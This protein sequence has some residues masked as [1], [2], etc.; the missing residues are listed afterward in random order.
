MKLQPTIGRLSS[1]R[2]L[3]KTLLVALFVV[4]GSF[5]FGQFAAPADSGCEWDLEALVT[6]GALKGDDE[7]EIRFN[8][9]WD[10][11][12]DA[13][14]GREATLTSIS[15]PAPTCGATADGYTQGTTGWVYRLLKVADDGT[16]T[17]YDGTTGLLAGH[18]TIGSFT[19]GTG[20][21]GASS[22]G[23]SS[24]TRWAEDPVTWKLEANWD[25]DF[26]NED[27]VPIS[28]TFLVTNDATPHAAPTNV[29]AVREAQTHMYV[30]WTVTRVD[31]ADPDVATSTTSDNV[32][33]EVDGACADNFLVV[34]T[35]ARD[36]AEMGD[37]CRTSHVRRTAT[38][39][40]TDWTTGA[41]N[42][43]K[44]DDTTTDDPDTPLTEADLELVGRLG[45]S[46]SGLCYG[47]DYNVTV[48][49]R[50]VSMTGTITNHGQASAEVSV[51]TTGLR[52]EQ[53]TTGTEAPAVG[54]AADTRFKI[55]EGETLQIN[56]NTLVNLAVGGYVCPVTADD[57]ATT[58]FDESDCANWTREQS[59]NDFRFTA[60]ASSS[61]R[62]GVE[63]RS[64][65]DSTQSDD[66]IVLTG[67]SAGATR[68]TVNAR[69]IAG[70]TSVSG[71]I[72]VAVIGNN[73]PMFAVESAKITWNVGVEGE[74]E[75]AEAKALA[76]DVMNDFVNS[77]IDEDTTDCEVNDDSDDENCDEALYFTVSKR[78]DGPFNLFEI[79]KDED[80]GNDKTNSVITVNQGPFGFGASAKTLDEVLNEFE[81]DGAD[82]PAEI[83]LT[84][85]AY[86][87]IAWD[88][89]GS[90]PRCVEDAAETESETDV[91][92][93]DTMV[94]Y[95]DIIETENDK[96]YVRSISRSPFF[97]YGDGN[98]YLRPLTE[99][100]GGGSRTQRV[101]SRFADRDSDDLCFHIDSAQN[102]LQT[103]DNRTIAKVTNGG[104]STCPNGEITL[105]MIL[106]STNPDD[107]EG[108]ALLGLQG[109]H[110]VSVNVFACELEVGGSVSA[111]ERADKCSSGTVKV[112][113]WVVYGANVGP[114][115][116][117]TAE[118]A[119]GSTVISDIYEVT[120]GSGLTL[121][122][123]ATDP[124]PS[125][126]KL[127]W[128]N[129]S[130]CSPCTG[131]EENYTYGFHANARK[132]PSS[133]SQSGNEYKYRIRIPAT[134]G[135]FGSVRDTI[136]YESL[137]ADKVYPVRVCA[138]DLHNERA[139]MTF[140]VKVKDRAESPEVSALAARRDLSDVFMLVGD[141]DQERSA[142]R[143]FTDSDGD[144]LEYEAYCVDDTGTKEISCSPLRV[145]IDDDGLI[146][147]TP[148]TSDFPDPA[149]GDPVTQREWTVEVAATSDNEDDPV[150]TVRTTFDVTVKENNSAPKFE[151]GLK[152][153]T[154]EAPE[155]TSTTLPTLT[156][157]DADGD[158]DFEVELS[159]HDKTKFSV[160]GRYVA[161]EG[162]GDDAVEV[163]EY[164]V[165][166]RAL[167]KRDFEADINSYDMVVR[168]T[169]AYGGYAELDVRV[170]TT[171][172]NEKPVLK[173][174]AEIED[175]T[176]LVGVESCIAKASELFEDPDFRD[177]QA[178]L[179]IEAVTTRPGD[180][181]VT[182]KKNEDIC[183]TG[184]NIG[185]GPGRVTVTAS[186][187]DD[188]SVR[189]R[190][191]VT[192]SENMAPTVVGD[193]IP[194]QTIQ[195]YGRSD[196]LNLH[197]YFDDGDADFD[198]TLTF[199]LEMES[200]TVATGVLLDGYKLRIYAD[201]KGE[202]MATIHA[203]DQNHQTVSS[204]FKVI[205]E[206]NDAP[207]VV[208]SL[209]DV[210]RFIGKTYPLIDATMIFEDPGDTL[211]YSVYT[212]DVDTATAA[213]KL[214]EQGGPWIVIHLHSPGTTKVTINAEDSVGN[215]AS[216]S[217]TL[218]VHPRNDP[219]T[220]ANEIDD[221]ELEM[222]TNTDIDISDTF[223][224]EGDLTITIK[225]ENENIAD[226]I[227]RSST[228]VIRIYANEI[229]S[230]TVVVTATDNIG[231]T[232]HDEFD[233]TV[234]EPAPV[235]PTNEP[236]VYVGMVDDQELTVIT[237]PPVISLVG[238][239]EDPNGD[240]LTYS[241]MSDD[242][243]VSTVDLMDTDLTIN[244]LAVGEAMITITATDGE[245]NVVGE[246]NVRV[247][248]LAPVLVG[249]I[250][251]QIATVGDA[252]PMVSIDGLFSDPEGDVLTYTATSA[253]TNVATVNLSGLDLTITPH[254]AGTTIISITAT[255]GEFNVVG[256]FDIV[257]ETY[258]MAQGTIAD[259]TLQIGGEDLAMEV[260][261]YFFDE[262]GDTLTYTVT[263]S[264]N[265]ATVTNLAAN[266]TM[267][268][269]T[270]GATAVTITA[271]DPK[272]RTAEQSFT[273][274]VS[275]SE[276][277]NVAQMAFAGHA[278]ITLGS[279]STA[280]SSRLES[281]RSDT[282][283]MALGLNQLS[284][285]LPIGLTNSDDD[286]RLQERQESMGFDFDTENQ[287]PSTFQSGWN[288]VS[289]NA[290]DADN[291]I[292]LPDVAA[293]FE[294]GFSHNL[295]GNGGIGS[296]SIWGNA[297]AQNF[298]GEGYEGSSNSLYV[299]VDVQSNECWLW[300][301]SVARNNAESDYSWGT[302]TQTM[303]TNMT[304]VLPYFSYEPT[305]GKTSV[306]G[307]VGRGSGD[308]ET[309]VVNAA[310][311]V[312][313]LSF[314]MGMLGGRHEFAKAGS[315]Q[316]AFRGDVAFAN[317]ETDAGDGAIDGLEASV[318]RLRAGVEGSFTVA[319][320]ANG[321]VTPFG[322]LAFRN[323]GGDG[324]TGTGF[325]VAGG[326]RMNTDALTVE[327]VGR[328][329]ASHSAEDFSENGVSLMLSF[330]P[331]SDESGFQAS[332]APSWGSVSGG[333]NAIWG[334]ATATDQLAVPSTDVF[335][336]NDGLSMT[337]SMRYGIFLNQEKFM[338]T[339]FVDY[340]TANDGV[341]KSILFGT[342]L[343]QLFESS[344]TF[345][346][347]MLVG[348]DTAITDSQPQ[349]SI[350]ALLRF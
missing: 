216:E 309:T 117:P 11:D 337:S 145:S 300:G 267:I 49:G 273:V 318:N 34:A 132:D 229:G 55:S 129:S 320:G 128:S 10:S 137:G 245:F 95:V 224:D 80:N 51:G 20:A 194:D 332:F 66:V 135:S 70:T 86:D 25:V 310:N 82:E 134:T 140:N 324:L 53:A 61:S 266:V 196:D 23:L 274:N 259:Q 127:C 349:L 28:Y 62:L 264:G 94:I 333:S 198:E 3:F 322:E 39:T 21:T 213:I 149:E 75:R 176:I 69:E 247:I 287:F 58:T 263:S 283:S 105:S 219:P 344:R 164:R 340:K 43:F 121:T 174:D 68:L 108:F 182:V 239:F 296:F 143:V 193:G 64:D 79:D 230:T 343:T 104:K 201:E 78:G 244:P 319:T 191:S 38:A 166:L 204:T 153:V 168:V 100:D 180:A 33:C 203:T 19:A 317:M 187:R 85:T 12:G 321:S 119:T 148:P 205:V 158:T 302:A 200:S 211:E 291:L 83:T 334:E 304:T 152:G 192:V 297:D 177:Q 241:A 139:T 159:G 84:V 350:E 308:A 281:S 305:T 165:T 276:L 348:Q 77:T 170:D 265:A 238:L 71:S 312:S 197:A 36:L 189:L 307:V 235:E 173:E 270:R 185:S 339:P 91:D 124:L 96:P 88:G 329:T 199:E 54:S 45:A 106:P 171:D 107:E 60:S 347:R 279:V 249:T 331:S 218:T 181:S 130:F 272:G 280:I 17:D 40:I 175:Q 2:L 65:G 341:G 242:T 99:T 5:A 151:G 188:E 254:H 178:G 293:M 102:Q 52:D 314:N 325:E 327:A 15:I 202:T 268:P 35:L 284:Q 299:G 48:T 342:E 31:D 29:L 13:T 183:I 37:S 275:D 115:L 246:F 206:R 167:S 93:C 110:T 156:V 150:R 161:T 251:D 215:D 186:D 315:L 90:A 231:Q 16:E 221:V 252:A 97:G 112:Q 225:N 18:D 74:P 111:T 335:G 14:N 207:M 81:D 141:Y 116:L 261:Q 56:A 313:D 255:D 136:D 253:D 298:E 223:D 126:D 142:A 338:L 179:Y 328:V 260:G 217:F 282:G 195:E 47:E 209:P 256:T 146:T 22:F 236:P 306:W 227:Y 208:G 46:V 220:V 301:V 27:H 155:N 295:N 237:E 294:K 9:T 154:Y 123:T 120:E 289:G 7:N 63:Y 210:E 8:S 144:A 118:D 288:T 243:M 133:T 41:N 271:S 346:L 103:S 311:Q 72:D 32:F 214:D 228:E 184:H 232:A 250:D 285:Y 138:T 233:I 172:V 316:L 326:V 248:N 234:V 73:P 290:V 169:D 24:T 258:P 67:K 114:I 87:A 98:F 345:G 30:E 226:V 212:S 190:F 286:A 303:E 57:T 92:S 323:D 109:V 4:G 89:E 240:E 131:E 157:T 292:A 278:R 44:F 42:I 1:L 163:N 76:I 147:L 162:F 222:G 50:N 113:M 336:L 160:S 6:N 330:N 101:T 269:Y 257:V 26:P 277:K 262:D 125:G 59:Y 122:F